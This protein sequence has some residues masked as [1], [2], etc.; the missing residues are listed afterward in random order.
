M[1]IER[2]VVVV[3]A[4]GGG[5]VADAVACSFASA[6]VVACCT[7][8]RPE[9]RLGASGWRPNRG[10]HHTHGAA[11]CKR[12]NHTAHG[13]GYTA[14]CEW[15][16][17]LHVNVELRRKIALV[18]CQV[19]QGDDVRARALR[20]AAARARSGAVLPAYATCQPRAGLMAGMAPP[21]CFCRA[22]LSPGLDASTL[23]RR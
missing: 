14:D 22:R 18:G 3:V 19:A 11:F 16:A 21:A 1:G 13:G 10:R 23:P 2:V 12:L 20:A 4:V 5:V 17:F 8:E 9:A 6:G 15:S 7:A